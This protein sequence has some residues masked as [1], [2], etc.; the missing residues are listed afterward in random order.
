MSSFDIND[1]IVA[2]ATPAGVGGIAVVR[3]SGSRAL[4]IVSFLTGIEWKKET[5]SHKAKLQKLYSESKALIDEALILPM[6]G[7]ASYTGEDTIEFFCH[8]GNVV[9]ENI[10]SAC[11]SFG[12]R[13]ATAGEFTRRAFLNGKLSLDQSEAVVDLIHAETTLAASAALGQLRGGTKK[14][15]LQ[16][17]QPLLS[18]LAELEGGLE[19]LDEE[20]PEMPRN[21]L[22]DKISAALE[23]ISDLLLLAETGKSVRDGVNVVLVGAPNCGKSS[24]FNAML[25]DE[26]AI[27]D[28]SAGT[29]RDVISEAI[30]IDGLKFILHDTAGVRATKEGVEQKGIKKTHKTVTDADIVLLL[31]S[32]DTQP[33]EINTDSQTIVVGTKGDITQVECDI[34]TSSLEKT[35][36]EK[37][38]NEMLHVAKRDDVEKMLRMGLFLNER[39]RHKLQSCQ[40][41]LKD[42]KTQISENNIGDDIVATLLASTLTELGEISGRVYTESLLEDVFSK[43]CVGK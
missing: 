18:L 31:K 39:H 30:I 3:V 32:Q 24:L 5:E 38:K 6:L 14:E 11:V 9:A 42:L 1:T 12:A 41:N 21:Q 7:T 37:L 2:V 13:P 29:T 36:I 20:H 26:R 4:E 15:I 16:I 34:E 40:I 35:G 22:A 19:F 27:V 25:S 23:K 10:V 33:V 43:F 17:E 8:G 28:S